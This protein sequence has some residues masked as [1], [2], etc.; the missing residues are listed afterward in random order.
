MKTVATREAKN[1]CG[2]TASG[3]LVV[4]FPAQGIGGPCLQNLKH[5]ADG[6]VSSQRVLESEED[7][8]GHAVA[9]AQGPVAHKRPGLQL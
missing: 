5:K 4:Y 9:L 1:S 3:V 7:L 2:R 6:R 8:W